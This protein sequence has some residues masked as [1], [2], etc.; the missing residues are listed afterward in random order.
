MA[1][2]APIT[3]RQPQ[4]FDL[5]DEPLRVCGIGS[6]FGQ[7]MIARVRDGD[8]V[9]L[10]S[11]AIQAGGI[12]SLGNFEVA[13][14]LGDVPQTTRGTLQVFNSAAT[15]GSEINMV[16]IPIVFGRALIDS[17]IGFT[18]HV[19]VAGESLSLIA[20]QVYGS[21]DL[22]PRIFEAN[23]QQL[24]DPTAISPGQV[25]RVPR[26]LPARGNQ[27]LQAG[28]V[29]DDAGQIS[30]RDEDLD[31]MVQAGVGRIKIN[32]RLGGFQNWTETTTFGYS[33][34]G[35]YD[36]ILTKA[37]MRG[38]QVTGLLSN[39]A[40][41]GS[42]TDW[43]AGSAEAAG[44]TGNNPYLTQFAQQVAVPV[45]QHFAGQIMMWEVWNEPSQ[46]LTHLYPSNFAW[47]LAQ[48]YSSV[49]RA[50]IGNV[51][52]ISGGIT[53]EPDQAG[54]LTSAG[55]G[56]DYLAQTYAQGIRL[57]GW[58][59]IK[60]TYGSFPFDNIGQ[61]LYI[62][63]FTPTTAEHVA[64]ALRLLRAAYVAAEGGSTSKQTVITEFGW[65]TAAVP[66]RIQAANLQIAYD[67]FRAAGFVDHAYWFFL[68]DEAAAKLFFG[69]LAPSGAPK[70]AWYA[71]VRAAS[72]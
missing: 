7:S 46:P 8:G 51:T 23:R 9:V 53:A 45:I 57:A 54:A 32:F 35:L 38:L 24:S 33:A 65:T 63:P 55:V 30:I 12:G 71:F 41:H 3:V 28:A 44:G 18:Q 37:R 31:A 16:T 40:W 56:A 49:K 13:L 1:S 60:A 6:G 19:V 2:F 21:V 70:P 27:G 47:L 61:H 10:A 39:E 48:V 17:Y 29:I 5:V 34:L 68:R 22:W 50:G 20:Q 69:L 64:L 43:Q 72:F 58:Q 4:P 67:Q 66:A 15:D 14:A 59:E 11:A 42:L 52:F 26:G 36:Q 25:L 62:D